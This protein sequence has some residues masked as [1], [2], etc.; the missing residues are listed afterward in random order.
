MNHEIRLYGPIGGA[1]GIS[2]EQIAKEIPEDATEITVKIHSPG[3]SVG[4][5]LA[6]YHALR[7]HT[8]NVVTIVDGYAASAASFVMLAGDEVRVHRNSIVMVHNPWT[9]AEGN[10]DDLRRTAD[11]LDVHTDAIIDIY[12]RK[13]GKTEDELREMMDDETYFRGVDAINMGFADTVLDDYEEEQA[14]AA[15]LRVEQVL[16]KIQTED[17]MSKVQTRKEIAA[18]LEEAQAQI[19]QADGRIVELEA[20]L[21]SVKAEHA[22]EIEGITAKHAQDIE[23]LQA[24]IEGKVKEVESANDAVNDAQAKTKE[25]EDARDELVAKVADMEAIK[26]DLESQLEV[27]TEKLANPA[28]TDAS[29]QGQ[30]PIDDTTADEG[31]SGTPHID[32]Y[33]AISDPAKKTAYWNKHAT[34]IRA[35][36]KNYSAR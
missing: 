21:E 33:K 28:F 26:A 17:K 7:D 34:D 14:I 8:A 13:T 15:M 32:A 18:S 10:A 27:A 36:M 29:A 23:A 24:E 16:A 4:D 3:G 30:E 20:S 35:E 6:L 2:A 1:F 5:G 22:A 9:F 12:K 19:A 25:A 11:S 31:A